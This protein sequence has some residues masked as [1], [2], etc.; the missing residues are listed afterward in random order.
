MQPSSGYAWMLCAPM[1]TSVLSSPATMVPSRLTPYL[2]RI[3]AGYLQWSYMSSS[4]VST[5]LTGLR[6]L[7]ASATQMATGVF[8]W[9]LEPNAPPMLLRCTRTLLSG[10][11]K[12][13]P[14]SWRVL[15]IDCSVAQS[16]M[17]PSASGRH[18][19]ALG[20]I[21]AWYTRPVWYSRSTM[22]S[23]SSKPTETSPTPTWRK[24]ATLCSTGISTSPSRTFS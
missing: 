20:S 2:R 4:R 3:S 17:P 19:A 8:I 6:A 9:M 7:S 11:S 16:S 15:W 21:W 5:I 12:M 1:S 18:I 14:S 22:R 10:R 13:R 24:Q 23:A